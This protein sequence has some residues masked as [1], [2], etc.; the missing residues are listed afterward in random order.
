MRAFRHSHV[1][2]LD[3][4][5]LVGN[6][7]FAHYLHWQGHSRERFL[8]EHA[9]GVLKQVSVGELALV[10]V[11]CSM[12]FFAECFALERIEV[13]MTLRERGTNRIVMD[14]AFRRADV[15]IATGTQTVAC[16]RREG[17]RMVPIP[18]PDELRLALDGYAATT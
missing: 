14:F 7:Y 12:E 9:P 11:S 16:M 8:A 15:L 18:V 3:E 13:D 1:V 4:T 17:E 10:T 5:N 6:V 2:T